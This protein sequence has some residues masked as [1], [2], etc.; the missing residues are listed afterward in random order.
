M[1]QNAKICGCPEIQDEEWDLAEHEWGK[2]YFMSQRVWM[3]FHLPVGLTG[4]IKKTIQKVRDNDLEMTVPR[5][6]MLE[7]GLFSGRVLVEVKPQESQ[8]PGIVVFE[9][10]TMIGKVFIGEKGLNKGVA[11]LL[12][13][14][15]SKFDKHPSSV[16]FWYITCEECGKDQK[17]KT[18]ILAEL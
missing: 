6:I 1:E 4:R 10:A 9:P 11:E 17:N 2:K 8:A 5:R 18:V 15:R 13:Y 14:I 16:F 3:F 12:S 7:D